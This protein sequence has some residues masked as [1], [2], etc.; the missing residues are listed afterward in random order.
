[1]EVYDRLTERPL[2]RTDPELRRFVV[3]VD[4]QTTEVI[5][6]DALRFAFRKKGG[7]LAPRV[8][9]QYLDADFSHT[10]QRVILMGGKGLDLNQREGTKEF[11]DD[12]TCNLFEP[13]PLLKTNYGKTY[14]AQGQTFDF[15]KFKGGE[16][17]IDDYKGEIVPVGQYQLALWE[18]KYEV[19]KTD[20]SVRD[21]DHEKVTVT[22][23]V[24]E[25]LALELDVTGARPA[26]RVILEGRDTKHRLEF[27]LDFTDTKEQRGL[28]ADVYTASTSIPGLD[29][30][31]QSAELLPGSLSP[32]MYYTRSPAYEPMI[33]RGAKKPVEVPRLTIKTRLVLAGRLDVFSRPPDPLAADVFIDKDILRIL[34]LLLY[35]QEERPEEEKGRLLKAVGRSAVRVLEETLIIAGAPGSEGASRGEAAPPPEAAVPPASPAPPSATAEAAPAEENTAPPQPQLPRDLDELRQLLA[36]HL[37]VIDL[38]VLDPQDI[39]QLR[40][41][42]EVAAIVGRFVER[43]GALFAFISETGDYGEVVG[44]P[45][46]IE[47]AGKPT[48]R[49]TLA[50]GEVAGIVPRFDKKVGVKSKRALPE[51]GK[52]SPQGPWRV[53]A[54]TQGHKEPRI[55]E[56]GKREDGGY[57]VL[58]FDDP[59]SFRGRLGGTVPKV[60]ETRAKLEERILEWARYLMY[61]RYDKNGEQRRHAEQALTR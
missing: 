31:R 33:T 20:V 52:L 51:L 45:L 19:E 3:R 1:V 23:L 50:P 30:W 8:K 24:R 61:R 48:D 11:G 4:P 22:S 18:P 59:E 29:A 9:R 60:E 28:P 57:V 46:V 36:R 37:E 40:R 17:I 7:S 15:D 25:T 21:K 41:S 54:F 35:G 53:V 5:D 32:P 44:A 38:L 43:G 42:P 12:P 6:G 34:N 16:L 58:W 56:R 2:S 27:P 39:A 13:R 55:I 10:P 14:I 47:A 49:F 26:N